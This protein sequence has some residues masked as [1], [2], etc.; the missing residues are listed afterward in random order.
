MIDF[1][2]HRGWKSR[3]SVLS[4]KKSMTHPNFLDIIRTSSRDGG[5][6]SV[7]IG[8]FWGYWY[9]YV[10]T[11]TFWSSG[12]DSCPSYFLR[13]W[14]MKHWNYLSSLLFST[15]YSSTI[16]SSTFC[17]YASDLNYFV[18]LNFGFEIYMFYLV[19]CCQPLESGFNG[20]RLS[21]LFWIL[22]FWAELIEA[23]IFSLRYVVLQ[24]SSWFFN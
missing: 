13:F 5:S 24:F 1:G 10:S 18:L 19:T 16:V 11:D 7:N 12:S 20:N 8:I 15:L 3:Q 21:F 4:Q 2:N 6:V 22:C 14:I 23:L 9:K 17:L